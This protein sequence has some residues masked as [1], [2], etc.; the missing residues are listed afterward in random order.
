MKKGDLRVWHIPQVPMQAFHVD[1]R[2]ADEARKIIETLAKYDLFQLENRIK[3]DYSN[4]SGL[5]I[6]DGIAWCEWEDDE[7]NTIDDVL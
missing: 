7:G 6:F 1:V 2:S 3:P 4:A 5:E